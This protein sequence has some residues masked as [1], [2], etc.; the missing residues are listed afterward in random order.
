MSVTAS[1]DAQ[2]RAWVEAAQR[3]SAAGRRDDAARVLEQARVAAPEH[4]LVLNALGM[5]ALAGGDAGAARKFLER[6]VAA[7]AETPQ[8]WLSLALA[9]RELR[10]ATA[11]MNALDQALKLDPYFFL[12][13]MQKAALLERQG[14]SK[15]ASTAYHAALCCV[16]RTGPLPPSLQAAVA[17]AQAVVAANAAALEAFLSERLNGVRARHA[18]TQQ[19][20]FDHCLD[21]LLAKRRVFVQQPTY[22]H[23]PYL[24][25]VQFYERA[26]FP[27]LDAL[28]AA[29]G[30]MRD[31]L[32]RVMT[33]DAGELV[34]YVTYPDGVPLNQWAELNHSRKWSVFYLLKDGAR[35][36]DH[37]QRCPKTA[38]ALSRPPLAD[39]PGHAPTAF[40]SILQPHTHIPPHTGVTNTRLV[41]HVPLIVPGSCRFRVG[42][43]TREWVPGKAWVFDDTIEHE[44]W[45]DSDQARAILIVD[46]WNPHLTEAERDLVRA[47]TEGVAG[48]YGHSAF[49][50]GL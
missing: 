13:L 46:I 11:E 32:V 31:E 24:P 34:P 4:P 44:A 17:H 5:H 1:S 37:L 43:E 22:M 36:E 40:F 30:D 35:L 28:E 25:A 26:D 39:V 9:C 50:D 7:H 49:A 21:V 47:A 6:A 3:A 8:L 19:N 27:W 45:N 15:K 42:S 29:A 16:P 48:F 10:D 41:V 23:F 14:D 20:R 2:V 38:A 18:G 12:A 33:E